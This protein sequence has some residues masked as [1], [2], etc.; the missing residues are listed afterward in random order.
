MRY[1]ILGLIKKFVDHAP[2]HRPK[3]EA[4]KQYRKRVKGHY[5]RKPKAEPPAPPVSVEAPIDL[6]DLL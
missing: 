3:S 2:K 5:T 1:A 6:G 4:A